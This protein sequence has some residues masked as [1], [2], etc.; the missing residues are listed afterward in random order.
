MQLFERT[1]GQWLEHWAEETPD[2]EYIVWFRMVGRGI[3]RRAVF[4]E[5]PVRFDD[6]RAFPRRADS[7]GRPIRCNRKKRTGNA[8][9]PLLPDG[10]AHCPVR[11]NI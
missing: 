6:R 3:R 1:L 9:C 7:R 2:K 10:K 8:L 5:V 4:G 11:G